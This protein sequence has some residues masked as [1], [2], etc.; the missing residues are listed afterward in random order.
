[1]AIGEIPATNIRDGIGVGA[2][3]GGGVAAVNDG[4]DGGRVGRDG[5]EG[6]VGDDN[7]VVGEVQEVL[8]N[9]V[10]RVVVVLVGVEGELWE[11]WGRVG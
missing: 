10:V 5:V 4:G 7:V 11:N 2:R 1:M 8:H 6:G 3:E 9:E